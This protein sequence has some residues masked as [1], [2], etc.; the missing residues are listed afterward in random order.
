[1]LSFFKVKLIPPL[2]WGFSHS[3]HLCSVLETYIMGVIY[4]Q[5]KTRF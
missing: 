2:L 4:L 5:D 1:M 3:T